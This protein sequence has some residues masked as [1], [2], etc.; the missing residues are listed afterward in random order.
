MPHAADELPDADRHLPDAVLALLIFWCIQVPWSLWWF[1]RHERGPLEALWA[2]L[3]YG[4][5][6]RQVPAAAATRH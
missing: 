5:G 2:G 4:P 1:G 6:K 3:T